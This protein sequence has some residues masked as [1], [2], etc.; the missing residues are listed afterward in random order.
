LISACS[1]KEGITNKNISKR[2]IKMG[3]KS[4]IKKIRVFKKIFQKLK[5]N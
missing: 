3:Y 5:E 4:I 2:I 1:K